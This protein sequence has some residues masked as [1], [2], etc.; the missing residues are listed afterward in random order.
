MAL[1]EPEWE[2]VFKE[3]T[4]PC[5]LRVR[6]MEIAE[7]DLFR[8]TEL[9]ADGETMARFERLGP[10]IEPCILDV[11]GMQ[12]RNPDGSIRELTWVAD[13]A[14]ILHVLRRVPKRYSAFINDVL[15]RSMDDDEVKS[16]APSD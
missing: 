13:K 7:W 12:V 8:R 4:P 6:S 5:V 15:R 3:G 1:F 10:I 2:Y 9:S 11:C 16:D 14:L